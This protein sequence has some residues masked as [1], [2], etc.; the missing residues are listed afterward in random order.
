MLLCS[1]CAVRLSPLLCKYLATCSLSTLSSKPWLSIGTGL[2]NSIRTAFPNSLQ[3]K[4]ITGIFNS[5][6][7]LNN[8]SFFLVFPIS[9][10]RPFHTSSKRDKKDYYEVLGIPKTANAKDI[11]KAYYSVSFFSYLLIQN[12]V[13]ARV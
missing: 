4:L 10:S 6:I 12:D 13:F 3:P 8:F 11:K 2:G 5:N 9:H 7:H 1:N